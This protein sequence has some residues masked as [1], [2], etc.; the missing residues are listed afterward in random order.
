MA[1]YLKKTRNHLHLK[2]IGNVRIPLSTE[3]EDWG[4]ILDAT[5]RTDAWNLVTDGSTEQVVGQNCT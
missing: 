4:W 1:I 3:R 2:T 5:K